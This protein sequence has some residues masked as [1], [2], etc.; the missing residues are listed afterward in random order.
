MRSAIAG[1]TCMFG[2]LPGLARAGADAHKVTAAANALLT[3]RCFKCHGPDKSRGG[4]RLD[5]REAAVT[6][7]DSGD[8]ALVPGNPAASALLGRI[9]N[10]DE[11][12]RMPPKAPPL[13]RAEVQLLRRWVKAGAPY[14]G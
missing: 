11:S 9:T 8:P 7:G 2:L 12:E 5:R 10:T 14:P 13:S 4:L 3:E 6:G 1:L